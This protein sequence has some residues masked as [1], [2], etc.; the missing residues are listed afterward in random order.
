MT[1]RTDNTETAHLLD[2]LAEKNIRTTACHICRDCD[3]ALLAGILD[4]F[5][6]LL[7]ELGIQDIMRNTVLAQK[8]TELLGLRD[9]CRTDKNRTSRRM[10][11]V[12]GLC[13][14][15]IFRLFRLI[16]EVRLIYTLYRTVRRYNDNRQVIDFEELV[17]LCLCRTCHTRKLAVHAEIVLEGN[18]SKSLG[19]TLDLNAFLS[20]NSLM[21][22]LGV[23]ASEHQTACKFIDNN[24]L[25]VPDNIIPVALHKC[26]RTESRVEAV[27]ILDILRGIKIL[28]AKSALNL[29][30]RFIAWGNRFLL[31][32]NLVI[33]AFTKRSDSSSHFHINVRGFCART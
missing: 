2:A 3:R 20:L 17:F 9:G 7:M 14:G 28:Y 21:K 6:F 25:A 32:V 16:D 27:G 30:H 11:L 15:L 33:L 23:T 4:Y 24:N 13:N 1:L 10:H 12:H 18:G 8:G 31:F 29:V 26:L 5:S 19:L 22:A